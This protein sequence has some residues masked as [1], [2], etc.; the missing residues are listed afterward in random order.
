MLQLRTP[1]N[2]YK[3]TVMH[4][5]RVAKVIAMSLIGLSV[6]A[7]QSDCLQ[8]TIPVGIYSK[9]GD[10]ALEL[11]SASLEGSYHKKPVQIKAVELEKKP[12]RVV[13]LID[14]SGSMLRRMDGVIDAAE[15]VLSRF[16]VAAEVGLAFFAEKM[17]PVALPTVDRS[18]LI[19]QLE[20]L[21]KNRP[22]FRGKTA[23]WTA[24]LQGVKMFGT[25]SIGNAIYVISDANENASKVKERDVEVLLE[26]IGIRL[27]ALVIRVDLIYPPPKTVGGPPIETAVQLTGG[28][29]IT[30]T[31][32]PEYPLPQRTPFF[33][34]RGELTKLEQSIERQMVQLTEFYQVEIGLP[35]TV[36]KPEDWKLDVVGVSRPERNSLILT[37]PIQLV[38]CR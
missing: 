9:N 5:A 6:H 33:D 10:Q 30:E 31:F 38:P 23:L 25:P 2:Y 17:V 37:Y 3:T 14:T 32:P 19:S 8:R 34:T 26:G 18:K 27:F 12:Q 4:R 21:R 13:L 29:L 1:R 7:E 15:R 24:I 28:T 11:T 22:S 16:P 36:N 35:E 20:A